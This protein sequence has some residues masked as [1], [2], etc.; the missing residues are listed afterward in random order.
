[1][2]SFL[3]LNLISVIFLLAFLILFI[4]FIALKFTESKDPQDKPLIL[5]FGHRFA[6]GY[7]VG[8][9][10]K[11]IRAKERTCFIFYPRD[12]DYIRMKDEKNY[13][14]EPVKIWVENEKEETLSR[15][16]FSE[17]RNFIFV[18]PKYSEDL[19]KSFRN[20]IIGKKI[21]EIVEESNTD[22]ERQRIYRK[23]IESQEQFLEEVGGYSDIAEN[24]VERLNETF[25]EITKSK[26]SKSYPAQ[27]GQSWPGNSSQ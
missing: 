4:Y 25:K 10:D 18:Y 24:Y 11:V 5:I 16:T 23:R 17:H 22:I 15:I 8:F 7:R 21:M 14:V 19:N 6:K 13:K 27:G 3:W 12:L 2:V 26:D 1:M 9:V 20:T